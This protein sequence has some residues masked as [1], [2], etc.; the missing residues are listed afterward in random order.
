M[1]GNGCGGRVAALWRFPVKS[2]AGERLEAAAFTARGLIGDRA[3]ALID[4]ETGKVASAKS[5]RLFPALLACRAAF[6]ES[7]ERGREL[8]PVRITL[9]DGTTVTSDAPDVAQ[10]LSAWCGRDV[11]LARTAPEDFTVDQ[12]HPDVEHADPAG[13]R[14]TFVEQ[15]LG[16]AFFRHAGLPSP[17]AA[18]SFVDLFPVSLLSTST[19]REL[20]AREPGSRFDE[21]RFRMNVIVDAADSGFPENDWPGRELALGEALRVA[22]AMPDPRCVMTTLE[23]DD[24]PA[25]TGVLRA[26]VRHNRLKVGGAGE[27]PCA[28]VYAVVTHEGTVRVGDPVV[29]E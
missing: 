28:G 4:C 23:Q 19:L 1:S 27:F 29:V 15:K 5:A 18:D 24:L 21:R 3:Y 22:V 10:V 16:A 25:D 9:P 2:T 8:P 12:Y 11:R 20:H 17:V 7:P 13:Y 26:L 6:L 14:D